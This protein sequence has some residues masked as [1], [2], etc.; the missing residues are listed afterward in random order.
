M[1]Q[2]AC[3]RDQDSDQRP[4]AESLGEKGMIIRL[5]PLVRPNKVG[6]GRVEVEEVKH[7][8]GMEPI[9]VRN[10]LG[11]DDRPQRRIE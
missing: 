2:K 8:S 1:L 11:W 7:E 5:L 6:P 10:Y 4:E 9:A 3:R